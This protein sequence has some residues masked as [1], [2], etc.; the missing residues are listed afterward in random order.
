[1]AA[2][3]QPVLWESM[4]PKVWSS[5]SSTVS[6]LWL[7]G[8]QTNSWVRWTIQWAAS[9]GS[10]LG[11]AE[12]HLLKFSLH[13]PLCAALFSPVLRLTLL[14][15]WAVSAWDHQALFQLPFPGYSLATA[16]K[17]SAGTFIGLTVFLPS[18]RNHK[19]NAASCLGSQTIVSYILSFFFWLFYG[20]WTIP[21]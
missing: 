4:S 17:Q 15:S 2:P 20:R 13:R 11:L 7:V 19:L 1:M 16:A 8:R 21:A 3:E 14:R 6:P 18:L 10:C 5:G 9:V 12:F